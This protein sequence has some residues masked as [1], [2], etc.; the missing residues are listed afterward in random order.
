M[1]L[2]AGQ[3]Q[4]IESNKD[5]L[6]L[7]SPGAGKTTVGLL[8]ARHRVANGLEDHQRV[9]FLSFSNSAVY[10]IQ[11]AADISLSLQDRKKL[12]VRTFHSLCFELLKCYGGL[13][14]AKLPI[15][16]FPPEDENINDNQDMR[17]V[18]RETGMVT[19]NL[20]VVFAKELLGRSRSIAEVFRH[21]Y[22]LV[23][24]DEFQDTD[25]TE[26]DLINTMTQ[27]GQL[28]CLAD[29]HQRIYD[30]RP[31]VTEKRIEIL[32][33]TRN[34]HVIDLAGDNFRSPQ[35]TV[36]QIASYVLDPSVRVTMNG[37][38]L[39]NTYQYQNQCGVVLKRAVVDLEKKIAQDNGIPR[40]SVAIVAASNDTVQIISDWLSKKTPTA[41]FVLRHDILV[42]DNAL[43]HSWKTLARFMEFAGGDGINSKIAALMQTMAD[44]YKYRN[45]KSA[46]QQADKLLRWSSMLNTGQIPRA[47]QTPKKITDCLNKIGSIPWSGN[48]TEDVDRTLQALSQCKDSYLSPITQYIRFKPPCRMGDKITG[49]VSEFYKDNRGYLGMLDPFRRWLV[50]DRIADRFKKPF[51]RILMTMHKCKGREYDGMVIFDGLYDPHRITLRGDRQPYW[52]SRRVLRV[53][54]SRARHKVAV[55]YPK[56]N[57]S[58]VL[59]FL[60]PQASSNLAVVN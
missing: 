52:N 59:S 26:W 18:A 54:I 51:G 13:L 30:F 58:P 12:Q 21:K 60:L 6:V 20:L 48:P 4:V 57:P 10:Q 23:I 16:I 8:K 3:Q 14:G 1:K 43:M 7:G 53:A 31:G 35:S 27:G 44:F 56:N 29:P 47:T 22:P 41:N 17:R 37:N 25:D 40:P 32:R 45:S 49:K 38:V 5:L 34:P 36:S 33:Q 28:V 2:S 42:D 15:G 46:N 9:L 11:N 50:Q 24:V 39:F 19:F 55:V